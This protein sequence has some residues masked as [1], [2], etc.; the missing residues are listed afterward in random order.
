MDND[1]VRSIIAGLKRLSR[2]AAKTF[3]ETTEAEPIKMAIADYYESPVCVDWLLDKMFIAKTNYVFS[4]VCH[5]EVEV[6]NSKY[7]YVDLHVTGTI[8]G[9]GGVKQ[10]IDER[11]GDIVEKVAGV[12]IKNLVA[13]AFVEWS[14]NTVDKKLQHLKGSL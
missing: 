3:L 4:C 14:S 6:K 12:T 10:E 9:D 11:R 1:N 2:T 8:N 13:D 5:L 7:D